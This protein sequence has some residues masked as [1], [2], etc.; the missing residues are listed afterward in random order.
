MA[1][2]ELT[3]AQDGE[4]IDADTGDTILLHLPENPS[5]GYRWE[6][7]QLR[8]ESIVVPRSAFEPAGGALGSGGTATWALHAAAAGES[9]LRLRQWRPWEG[10]ASVLARFTVTV[11]VHP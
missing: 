3:L 6:L 10:E 1:T 7:E 8:G 4:S 5:T 11:R 2:I 9:S